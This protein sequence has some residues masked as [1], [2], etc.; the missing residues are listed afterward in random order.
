MVI[1][2]IKSIQFMSIV[3][4]QVAQRLFPVR[5]TDNETYRSQKSCQSIPRSKI[6]RKLQNLKS[7][8]HWHKRKQFLK[9]EFCFYDAGV[10]RIANKIPGI[11]GN[12]VC[13]FTD[14]CFDI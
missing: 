13:G 6:H 8:K 10:P 3:T 5:S 9:H 7:K 14:R 2:R 1:M 4:K 12:T 11:T